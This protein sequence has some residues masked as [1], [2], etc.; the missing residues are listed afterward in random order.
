M[1]NSYV[2][3]WAKFW[4]KRIRLAHDRGPLEVIFGG[5][6][7][8]LPSISHVVPGD[9]IY[10]VFVDKGEIFVIACLNV[11]EVIEAEHYV[12][13][14]LGVERREGIALRR[15][16]SVELGLGHRLPRTCADLAAVGTGSE[17]L[18]DRSLNPKELE[19]L[20]L[21]AKPRKEMPLK[22]IADGLLKRDSS[23]R[24]HVR[25]VS[26]ETS[27]LLERVAG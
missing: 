19:S 27:R 17:L 11:T 1:G 24:S 22:Y 9:R 6:H 12:Y 5:P 26:E 25:R 3:L 7:V 14:R 2:T 16:A 21:G 13:E 4:I 20:C 15:L 10:P 18:W 8:S 23:L